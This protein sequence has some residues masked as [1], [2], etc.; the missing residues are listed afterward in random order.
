MVTR[1]VRW[2]ENLY[3]DEE[4]TEKNTMKGKEIKELSYRE[5]KMEM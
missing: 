1:Q 5:N 4:T 2:K 3:N